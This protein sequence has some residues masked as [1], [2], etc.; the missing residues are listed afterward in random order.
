VQEAGKAERGL[1]GDEIFERFFKM[2]EHRGRMLR[3][4]LRQIVQHAVYM[5]RR[6]EGVGQD[7]MGLMRAGLEAPKRFKL[8][9]KRRK[10]TQ[11]VD[12]IQ[13]FVRIRLRE[14]PE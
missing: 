8:G 2:G 10:E 4:Y 5:A 12:K 9:Q 7:I 14:D 1:A 6:L 3:R 11:G 13:M